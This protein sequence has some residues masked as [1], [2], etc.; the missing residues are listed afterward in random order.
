MNPTITIFTPTYNRAYTLEK[1]YN[2]L[3][4]QTRKDFCWLVI[5]DGS[6]DNTRDLVDKWIKDGAI[7]IKY[8][9]QENQGMHGAHNTA[10]SNIMT[11]L[12]L[13]CDSDDYLSDTALESIIKKWNSCGKEGHSGVIGWD[14]YPNGD[15]ISV[16]LEM[17]ETTTFEIRQKL[18]LNCDYKIAFRSELLK[19]D[20]LPLFE[21]EK[22]VPLDCKYYKI[23][24]N[25]K[26]LV[27]NEILCY[28]EYLPD[29]GTRNNLIQ[30]RNN[31]KG[32]S[33]FRKEILMLSNNTSFKI[34]FRNSTH[35]VASSL[36]SNNYSLF[37]GMPKKMTIALAFP[38]GFILYLYIKN[39]K[40]KSLFNEI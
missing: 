2:S 38:F 1:C 25:Y 13:C 9:Y 5:D 24:M 35:Y 4:R 8:L 37:S 40:K 21:G 7:E 28:V 31:P 3:L 19:G 18:R 11:E 22:Y 34:N 27:L 33:F 6:T 15:L 10:Y 26:L 36:I 29:G 32:F 20:P 16:K 30:Y 39:T 17:K 14:A 12:C 23:D